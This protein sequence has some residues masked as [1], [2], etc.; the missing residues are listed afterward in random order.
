MPNAVHI[1]LWVVQGGL[2]AVFLFAG[3]MKLVQPKAALEQRPGM[4]YVVDRTATE[5]KLLGLAE[6]LGA[7]GLVV[8]WLLRI[9][10]VL[11]P[12]AAACLAVLMAGA[13][14][15]HRRRHESAALPAGLLVLT[16]LVA[17]GRGGW[18]G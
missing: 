17:V 15:V 18:W 7:V 12:V 10:P 14:V 2:A 13:V 5:M 11:T 3:G 9:A 8:P 16:L 6:V 1:A 4:G